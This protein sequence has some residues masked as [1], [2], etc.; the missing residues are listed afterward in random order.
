M[1]WVESLRG[2]VVGLDNSPIIYFIQ[3]HPVYLPTVRSFFQA[4]DRGEFHAV[5][6]TVTL[7]EVLIHPFRRSNVELAQQYRG[8]LLNSN[9][10]TCI[11]LSS[12]IAEEAAR[13]RAQHNL[14]TSD[15]IQMA[16]AIHQGASF[17]FTNDGGLPSLPTLRMLVLDQLTS[18][19][20]AP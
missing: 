2:Q 6:S 18:E 5:T 7:L 15:A 19:E 13:L 17:F 11:A 12:A 9:G 4:L 8:I 20:P 14:Q 3:E 10:L 16:T 1:G